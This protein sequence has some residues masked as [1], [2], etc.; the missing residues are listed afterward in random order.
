MIKGSEKVSKEVLVPLGEK[1][2]FLNYILRRKYN[3]IEHILRI[4]WLIYDVIEREMIEVKG[5]ERRS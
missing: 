5:A 3:W 4:N 2:I 1:R